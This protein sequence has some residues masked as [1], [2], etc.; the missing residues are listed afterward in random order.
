MWWLKLWWVDRFLK[1]KEQR[2]KDWVWETPGLLGEFSDWD[3]VQLSVLLQLCGRWHYCVGVVSCHACALGTV[4]TLGRGKKCWA[5]GALSYVALGFRGW[6]NQFQ[7][8]AWWPQVSYYAI[9]SFSRLIY[10]MMICLSCRELVM[11]KSDNRWL[12]NAHLWCMVVAQ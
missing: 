2:E 10:K 1:C 4:L 6:Q 5:H 12:S 8:P 9:L 3:S 11:V 7:F